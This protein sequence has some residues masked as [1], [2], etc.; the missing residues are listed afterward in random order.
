MDNAQYLILETASFLVIGELLALLIYQ[1][2]LSEWALG[3][4][5]IDLKGRFLL[6]NYSWGAKI[7]LKIFK[8]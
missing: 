4:T 1:F 7:N 8:I 3:D 2:S 5:R 6:G